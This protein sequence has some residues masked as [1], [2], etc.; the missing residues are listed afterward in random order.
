MDLKFSPKDYPVVDSSKF[1]TTWVRGV[2]YPYL[3]DDTKKFIVVSFERMNC[4]K[5]FPFE[6]DVIG[7]DYNLDGFLLSL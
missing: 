5:P 3:E 4:G 7:Y 6:F 1:D 2:L